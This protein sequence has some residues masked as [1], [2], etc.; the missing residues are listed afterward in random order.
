MMPGFR[1]LF[2]ESSR[3]LSA[4]T[5]FCRLPERLFLEKIDACGSFAT[6]CTWLVWGK[7]LVQDA[8]TGGEGFFHVPEYILVLAEA[9]RNVVVGCPRST[10]QLEEIGELKVSERICW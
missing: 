9:G 10:R 5:S 3:R 8:E 1:T 4:K 2:T 7:S 6:L